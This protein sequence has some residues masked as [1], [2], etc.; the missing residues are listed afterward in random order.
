MRLVGFSNLRFACPGL[1]SSKG[2]RLTPLI[3]VSTV[4]LVCT[5]V[6]VDYNSLM[7]SVCESVSLI[8]W[9]CVRSPSQLINVLNVPVI[10]AASE[11]NRVTDIEISSQLGNQNI[12]VSQS[13][14][15]VTLE[16][17]SSSYRPAGETGSYM[18]MAHSP[19]S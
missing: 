1:N 11:V 5:R 10:K 12:C 13:T 19:A 18:L 8:M 14:P 15:V 7:M 17:C 4:S 16:G 3:K 6:A 9:C 2:R